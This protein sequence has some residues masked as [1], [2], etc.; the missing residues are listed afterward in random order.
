MTVHTLYTGSK[1]WCVTVHTFQIFFVKILI[2]NQ[3]TINSLGTFLLA[4]KIA[5]GVY[6]CIRVLGHDWVKNCRSFGTNTTKYLRVRG[7]F[8]NVPKFRGVIICEPTEPMASRKFS[9]RLLL[10]IRIL[11]KYGIYVYLNDPWELGII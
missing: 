6:L 3:Y 1:D 8:L 11:E 10:N 9:E 7:H 2:A 4:F 5:I